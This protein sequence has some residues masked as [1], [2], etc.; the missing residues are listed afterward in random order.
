MFNHLQSEYLQLNLLPFADLVKELFRFRPDMECIRLA[1]TIRYLQ[2]LHVDLKH[3]GYC[4][5]T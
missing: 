2:M 3:S 1:R 4:L 5:S